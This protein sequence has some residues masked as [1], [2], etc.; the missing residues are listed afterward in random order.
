MQNTVGSQQHKIVTEIAE[1]AEKKRMKEKKLFKHMHQM[2]NEQTK[3]LHFAMR[4]TMG[5]YG[6]QCT[7]S[8]CANKIYDFRLGCF[9]LLCI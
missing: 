4:H 3:N 6:T 9:K 2:K 1:P 5:T 8:G 7:R